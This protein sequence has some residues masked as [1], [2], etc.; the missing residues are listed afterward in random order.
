MTS[1]PSTRYDHRSIEPHWQAIWQQTRLHEVDLDRAQRPFYN[2]MMFPYP[3]AEGLHVGNVYAYTGADIYG[4]AMAMQGYDV[5]EPMGFD[6]FGIHSEN[7]A[8]KQGIHPARLTARNIERF[9]HDQLERIGCRYAWDQVVLTHDPSYYRWTQWIFVQLFKAGLAVQ[10]YAAV[11]WCPTDRTV[12]ADEQVID[13]HCE[14]C[15]TP[16]EQRDLK[17][18][19]L[20]ITAYADRLLD[21]L[22]RLDWSEKVKTAQRAWI[23]RSEGLEFELPVESQPELKISVFTTR[24]DTAFG[25]TYVVLP[26]PESRQVGPGAPAGARW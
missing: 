17:Q 6:A 8:I 1:I 2:L 26:R 13:G 3:S 21:N 23:G 9:R 11:N 15:D 16:V 18:W 4:R 12:L 25:M 19:F 10:K 22:D 20:R 24:P 7:F 14:R 5:F